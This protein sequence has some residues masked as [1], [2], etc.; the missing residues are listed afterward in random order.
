MLQA[1][2]ASSIFPDAQPKGFSI[3]KRWTNDDLAHRAEII[4][5]PPEIVQRDIP[6]KVAD[7][8]HV[9]K[10]EY[11]EHVKDLN[12]MCADTDR[13]W[14]CITNILVNLEKQLSHKIQVLVG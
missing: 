14:Y 5:H 4:N 11:Q 13:E 8:F 6:D 9:V 10:D 7:W 3:H 2:W 12:R 1:P